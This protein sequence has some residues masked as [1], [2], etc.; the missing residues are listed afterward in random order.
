MNAFPYGT[1]GEGVV[2]E[3]VYLPDWA[4]HKRVDYTIQTASILS[5]LMPSNLSFASISTLPGAYKATIKNSDEFAQVFSEN[6]LSVIQF[7]IELKYQTGKVIALGLEPE[8]CCFL[9]TM[10][11]VVNFFH[12]FIVSQSAISSLAKQLK[13]SYVDAELNL[14]QHLGVC[15]DFCHAAVEF[16]DPDHCLSVLLNNGISIVKAQVSSGLCVNPNHADSVKQLMM[17]DEQRYLHQVIEKSANRLKRFSDISNALAYATIDKNREWRVHFHVPVYDSHI[18]S[19]ATTQEF[20]I[21]LLKKHQQTPF[22]QH[23]EIETYT[24]NVL[25]KNEHSSA[26]LCQNI[27]KE[28]DWCMSHF[29]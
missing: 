14:R 27:I 1:F 2:K 17:F 18:Q 22:T 16:E 24:W 5:Q 8:P 21:E 15:L 6:L 3:N 10:D 9:E 13:L 11:E 4:S 19:L 29:S 12:E 26:T 7:L 28:L 23:F 25:P 20:V